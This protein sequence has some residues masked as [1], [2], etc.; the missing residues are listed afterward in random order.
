MHALPASPPHPLPAVKPL[1]AGWWWGFVLYVFIAVVHIGAL[2]IGDDSVAAPSKLL[3]MPALAAAI[4]WAE[5]DRRW[6]VPQ[7]LLLSAIALSWLGDGAASFFP[8]APTLP[9]ML[10]CFGLAHV[11]YIWLFTR[12]GAVRRTPWWTLVYAVWWIVLVAVLW[13]RLGALAVAVAAYGL[14]LA[15]TAVTS[16]RGHVLTAVGGALFLASDTILA[17][18]LF[19]PEL[20]PEIADALVMLTYCSGQGLIAV[21]LLLSGLAARRPR[22]EPSQV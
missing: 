22:S 19:T 6:G 14:V 13:P 5:R 12:Y 21:G 2:A 10:L 3:L 16:A 18:L 15:G 4:V 1:A 9:V 7:L 20:M 8:F 17:F 11:G